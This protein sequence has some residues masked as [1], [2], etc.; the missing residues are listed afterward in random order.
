MR[1]SSVASV[2]P[3]FELAT[4]GNDEEDGIVYCQGLT[5]KLHSR[6][7]RIDDEKQAT[8]ARKE[9]LMP[10]IPSAR[11]SASSSKTSS[12]RGTDGYHPNTPMDRDR[13][14]TRM[15]DGLE[16]FGETGYLPM[17]FRK[18]STSEKLSD[19]G[20]HFYTTEDTDR[21]PK[22]LKP[23]KKVKGSKRKKFKDEE[24]KS[25]DDSEGK[26]NTN[27]LDALSQDERGNSDEPAEGDAALYNRY[28]LDFKREFNMEVTR[29]FTFSYFPKIYNRKKK[30]RKKEKDKNNNN[31]LRKISTTDATKTSLY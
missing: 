16:I 11:S 28:G 20:F 29:P 19:T 30:E 6:F 10:P 13:D 2:P 17:N 31:K 21:L 26:I 22:I 4:N 25:N 24:S 14:K 15:E 1:K 5:A 7:G 27:Q 12:S 9:S 8:R 18:K 3:I 23:K